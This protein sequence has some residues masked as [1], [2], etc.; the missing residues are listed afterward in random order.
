[1]DRQKFAKTTDYRRPSFHN[2]FFLHQPLWTDVQTLPKLRFEHTPLPQ[3]DIIDLSDPHVFLLPKPIDMIL[4]SL[5]YCFIFLPVLYHLLVYQLRSHA[6][7]QVTHLVQSATV[8]FSLISI[9]VLSG[10]VRRRSVRQW[11]PL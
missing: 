8:W 1:M 5:L 7:H 9:L 4:I 3:S 10:G 11:G 6:I 2:R